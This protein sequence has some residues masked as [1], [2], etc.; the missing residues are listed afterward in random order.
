MKQKL[1]AIGRKTN[2][3]LQ[4]QNIRRFDFWFIL[5]TK[6]TGKKCFFSFTFIFIKQYTWQVPKVKIQLVQYILYMCYNLKPPW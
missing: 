6:N 4:T 3:K 1:E 2:V 5:L